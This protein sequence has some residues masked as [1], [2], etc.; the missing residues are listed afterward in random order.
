MWLGTETRSE[1]FL[2]EL[3]RGRR[4]KA[5]WGTSISDAEGKT[6]NDTLG[7]MSG[8]ATER[9][10]RSSMSFL[11][12]T[13]RSKRDQAKRSGLRDTVGAP[14]RQVRAS[15]RVKA[16]RE[17]WHLA[18]RPRFSG[19][20]RTKGVVSLLSKF[21]RA[22]MGGSCRLGDERASSAT[23]QAKTS[24]G[25]GKPG[26]TMIGRG[27]PPTPI[28][29]VTVLG[30]S[31]GARPARLLRGPPAKAVRPSPVRRPIDMRLQPWRSHGRDASR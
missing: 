15:G 2:N 11:V 20:A 26:A 18:L 24:S 1:F 13:R 5:F 14:L 12:V 31:L 22:A 10:R 28:T 30:A 9:S 8:G 16:H 27:S 17:H 3:V 23:D 4:G 25:I 21:K 29:I 6:S 7:R 19:K